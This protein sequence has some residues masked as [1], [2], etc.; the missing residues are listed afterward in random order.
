MLPIDASTSTGN[1]TLNNGRNRH[2][3]E[4]G[5]YRTGAARI[6]TGSHTANL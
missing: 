6:P 3:H 5:S 2:S 4:E 1:M